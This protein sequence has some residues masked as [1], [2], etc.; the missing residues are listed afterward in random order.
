MASETHTGEIAKADAMAPKEPHN[1]RRAT[2][3]RDTTTPGLWTVLGPHLD[4]A[5]PPQDL[6]LIPSG[7]EV[8]PAAEDMKASNAATAASPPPLRPPQQPW[9]AIIPWDKEAE[10][11]MAVRHN[12]GEDR[13]KKRRRW[14]W[15]LGVVVLLALVTA[16]GLGLGLSMRKKRHE[17]SSD[18]SGTPSAGSDS[19]SSVPTAS[20]T[21]PRPNPSDTAPPCPDA[22]NTI[23]TSPANDGGTQ[24]RRICGVSYDGNDIQPQLAQTMGMC[25]SLC[26][27]HAG[28]CA[29]VVWYD[30]GPQGTDLN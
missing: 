10:Q 5:P 27:G 18:G 23:Y 22:N 2:E 24:Y 8:L 9:A 28:G 25:L 19:T 20:L 29:G 17:E 16:L 11:K 6:N 1:H 12:E 14:I 26:S 3:K 13:G 15:A 30:A 4:T 7:L 21:A